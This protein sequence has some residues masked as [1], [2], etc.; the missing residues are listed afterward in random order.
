MFLTPGKNI[1]LFPE[2]QNL[3]PQN[4]F[5]ARLN[6]ETFGSA[7]MFPSL[8]R[9]L[10]TLWKLLTNRFGEFETLL[11]PGFTQIAMFNK[12]CFRMEGHIYETLKNGNTKFNAA[13]ELIV[14]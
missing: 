2:Q 10:Q 8:A 5:P 13:K 11:K 3:F 7:T 12:T 4:I 9:P 6:W 1:F 14:A